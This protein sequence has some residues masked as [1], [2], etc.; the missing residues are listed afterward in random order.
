MPSTSNLP[1]PNHCF[2]ASRCPC[3]KSQTVNLI[4]RGFDP[5]FLDAVQ[6]PIK[7]TDTISAKFGACSL[8]NLTVVLL[9]S[10]F[11]LIQFFNSGTISCPCPSTEDGPFIFRQIQHTFKNYGPGVRYVFFEHSGMEDMDLWRPSGAHCGAYMREASVKVLISESEGQ[12]N[13]RPLLDEW[14]PFCGHC[15]NRLPCQCRQSHQMLEHQF[16]SLRSHPGNEL[17]T[18]SQ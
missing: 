3:V 7:V 5:K 4:N 10:K 14:S 8:F 11:K 18:S 12:D 17:T 15:G 9:D 16:L 2:V 6:P 13:V 1:G